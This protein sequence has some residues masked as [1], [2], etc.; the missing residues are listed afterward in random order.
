M[1]AI[2]VLSSFPRL[3]EPPGFLAGRDK[4]QHLSAYFVLGMLALRGFA[5]GQAPTGGAA[6]SSLVIAFVFGA[7][8]ELHQHFV[9]GRT[10]D[11]FDWMSDVAGASI[12]VAIVGTYYRLRREGRSPNGR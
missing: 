11:V 7:S 5:W 6:L 9:P 2:F 12:G 8:D 4:L 10:C 1:A 3:P